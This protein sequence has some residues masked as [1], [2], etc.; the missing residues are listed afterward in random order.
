MPAAP[1]TSSSSA[2]EQRLNQVMTL[3][4][5]QSHEALSP[6]LQVFMQQESAKITKVNAK[7]LHSA[8]DVLTNAEKAMDAALNSRTNLIASWRT[9]IA[10]SLQTWQDY[11]AQFQKQEAKCQE[12]IQAAKIALEKAKADFNSKKP[13][14]GKGE[15][16]VIS[17][18]EEV[19]IPPAKESSARILAGLEQMTSSLTELSVQAELDHQEDQRRKRPRKGLT[20]EEN[21]DAEPN[22]GGSHFG[23]PGH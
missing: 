12:E 8:V 16:Q 7:Q 15:A 1:G 18:D 3:L 20:N 19:K 21:M 2:V 10:T 5:K 4:N 11:T 13:A 14:S 9:F 23:E 6:D 17:D 22:E